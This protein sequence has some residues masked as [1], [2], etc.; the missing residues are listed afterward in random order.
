MVRSKT[1]WPQAGT[2]SGNDAAACIAEGQGD[3]C[4]ERPLVMPI[5]ASGSIPDRVTRRQHT[6]EM[7]AIRPSLVA[8]GISGPW[9]NW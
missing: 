4:R 9:R 6:G 5:A 3:A 8:A 2:D 7:V 1:C